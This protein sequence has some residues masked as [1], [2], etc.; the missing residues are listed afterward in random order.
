[1]IK[2]VFIPT[3]TR[4]YGTN[5][6]WIRLKWICPI[7]KQPRGKVY[8]T[9]SYDGEA[10]LYCDSWTNLCGHID[11]YETIRQEAINNKLN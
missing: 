9:F 5:G 11:K 6:M 10:K 8:Q 1:M 4:H 2:R 3:A 7:C